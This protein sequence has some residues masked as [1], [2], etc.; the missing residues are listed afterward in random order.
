MSPESRAQLDR[1]LIEW[2]PV[3]VRL[4]VWNY[5]TFGAATGLHPN[6]NRLRRL[7]AAIRS[8]EAGPPQPPPDPSAA[9]V[10]DGEVDMLADDA[11]PVAKPRTNV[12]RTAT[13][14]IEVEVQG[15]DG[16]KGHDLPP[17]EHG[18]GIVRNVEELAREAEID[19]ARWTD[20]GTFQV[21]TWATPMRKRS[22]GPKGVRQTDSIQVV[23]SWYVRATFRRRLDSLVKPTDWGPRVARRP[24]AH[25]SPVMRAIAIPDLHVGY[26]WSR[27]HQRLISL[28]DWD[29]L[30]A[31]LQFVEHFQPEIIQ[32]LGDGLDNAAFS[33]KFKAKREL[34][35][36]AR[37]SILTMHAIL[38]RQRERFPEAEI[39]YQGGNH[40]E[41]SERQFVGTEFEGLKSADMPDEGPSVNSFAHLLRLDLLDV[42]WRDYGKKRWIFHENSRGIAIEHGHRVKPRGGLTVAAVLQESTTSV[43]F[44]HIHRREIASRTIHD[45]RGYH[46]ITVASPGTLARIDGTVPGVTGTPDWQHGLC[47]VFFDPESGQEHIDLVPIHRGRIFYR[48]LSIVGDGRRLAE[49]IGATIGYPQ[50]AG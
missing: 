50:I 17:S 22:Y 7:Y 47:P 35:D 6:S 4:P 23:R 16:G 44:G 15:N 30:D 41:R 10:D 28:H 9:R 5:E 38:R 39:D 25:A 18:A 32:Y 27:G 31:M 19:L 8:G 48:G 24:R 42:S 12:R 43:I 13:G 11:E 1:D 20:D 34:Q 45:A 26:R 2:G 36:T 46:E 14:D 21:R 33:E 49:E 40:E 29:A 3:L 37:P